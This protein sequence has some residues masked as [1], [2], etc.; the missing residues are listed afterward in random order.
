MI[1]K[2]CGLRDAE[3]IRAVERL[4]PDYMGFICWEGSARYVST[5]PDYLPQVCRVG[6]FVNP[7]VEEVVCKAKALGLN[8]IQLHGD[9]PSSLCD[10]V[11]AATGL[12]VI[13]AIAVRSAT[14]IA[15]YHEYEVCPSVDFFLFDTKC[16]RW[17]GSGEIFDW[18]VLRNYDGPKP[19]LL[20]G[21][22]APGDESRV[23]GL[24]HPQFAGIDLNS[25]FENAP[26]VKDIAKLELFINTLRHEQNQRLV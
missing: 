15:K 11:H 13:K 26:G 10:A 19:F 17:G 9:E 8:R 12:P 7:T 4:A 20:A 14:D 5:V 2:V 25:R 18:D 3:N 1:I 24:S 23:L 6:V 16:V 22:I 21:G